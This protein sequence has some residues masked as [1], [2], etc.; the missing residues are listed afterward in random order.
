MVVLRVS[1]IQLVDGS[2]IKLKTLQQACVNEF[3]K[4]PIDSRG[5]DVV[6][7]ATAW[8]T[9]NQLV[10]I[11]MVVLLENSLNEKFSLA[12]LSQPASLQVLLEP[13]A[14]R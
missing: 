13:L 10:G 7:L 3:P 9:I 2:P 8:Q 14:R 6:L 11:K 1:V 12:G 5:T 4:R